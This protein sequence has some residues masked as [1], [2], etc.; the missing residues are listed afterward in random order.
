MNR[1]QKYSSC[2][3]KNLFSKKL[4][5]ISF[6]LDLWYFSAIDIS[7]SCGTGA[8]LAHINIGTLD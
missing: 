8:S 2:F 1:I 6:V 4:G 3:Q 5:R 7:N